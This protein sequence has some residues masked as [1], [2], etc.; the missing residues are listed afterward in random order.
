MLVGLHCWYQ[1]CCMILWMSIYQ[2][3][4]FSIKW[5][6][7]FFDNPSRISECVTCYYFKNKEVLEQGFFLW[8][9][10]RK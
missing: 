10:M 8:T 1:Y 4:I 7:S 2:I 9:D 6:Q 5:Y 3:F